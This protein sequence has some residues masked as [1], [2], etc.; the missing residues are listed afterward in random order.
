[1]R[2]ANISSFSDDVKIY[3][4][5]EVSK[6]YGKVLI[7][8]SA[9]HASSQHNKK[10]HHE[11][12][13]LDDKE[14]FCIVLTGIDWIIIK[15]ILRGNN[16]GNVEIHVCSLRSDPIQLNKI[17]LSCDD[18]HEPVRNLLMQIKELLEEQKNKVAS[19]KQH[20]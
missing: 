1:M 10:R 13:G 3:S 5:C 16:Y 7:I 6:C 8:K 9:I 20:L 15:V 2:R 4:K 18:I 11:D 19:R 12:A 17:S 14:M